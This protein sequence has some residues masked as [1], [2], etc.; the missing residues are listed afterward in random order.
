[1]LLCFPLPGHFTPMQYSQQLKTMFNSM[2]HIPPFWWIWQVR[3]RI[4]ILKK[5]RVP[6]YFLQSCLIQYD[7]YT[8]IMTGSHWT[9]S[10]LGKETTVGMTR[11]LWPISVWEIYFSFQVLAGKAHFNRIKW[12][13]VNRS[14]CIFSW[15]CTLV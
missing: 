10:S 13:S 15:V 14:H 7:P 12:N 4:T 3:Q 8:T 5:S 6:S 11:G 2:T 1:M 9:P